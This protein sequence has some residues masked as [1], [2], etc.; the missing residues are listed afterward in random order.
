MAQN[1][2]ELFGVGVSFR[3][4]I[5]EDYYKLQTNLVTVLDYQT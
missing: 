1:L 3:L 5:M 2:G 4:R